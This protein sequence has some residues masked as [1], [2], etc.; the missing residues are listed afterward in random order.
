[1]PKKTFSE[2][3]LT[4]EKTAVDIQGNFN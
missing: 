2:Q 3:V 1:L 4:D